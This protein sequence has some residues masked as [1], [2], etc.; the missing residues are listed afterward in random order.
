V[1]DCLC[2]IG[3]YLYKEVC[4]NF[5]GVLGFSH[6]SV[7]DVAYLDGLWRW[8]KTKDYSRTVVGCGVWMRYI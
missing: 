8:E 5:T 1:A 3:V 2:N 7:V 6:F 4:K